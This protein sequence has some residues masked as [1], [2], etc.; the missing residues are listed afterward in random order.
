MVKNRIIKGGGI[1]GSSI[2]GEASRPL[3]S[4]CPFFSIFGTLSR[5]RKKNPNFSYWWYSLTV[6]A[7]EALYLNNV[8]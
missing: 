7:R 6:L 8:P 2:I 4:G 3:R 1:L 5:K